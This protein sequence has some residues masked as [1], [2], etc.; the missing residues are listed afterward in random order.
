[1]LLNFYLY[2]RPSE[3]RGLRVRDVVK[4]VKKGP[5]LQVVELPVAPCRSGDTLEDR[6][7]GRVSDARPPLPAVFGAGALRKEK[8]PLEGQRRACVHSHAQRDQHLPGAELGSQ[9]PWPNRQASPLP[10][11]ARGRVPRGRQPPEKPERHSGSRPVANHQKREE[12][13][14]GQPGDSALRQP[15]PQRAKRVSRSGKAPQA[16]LP[17]PAL[18]PGR[19]LHCGFFLEIFSGSGRLGRTIQRMTGWMVLLWDITLGI[20]YDLTDYANQHKIYNWAK[21]DLIL[22][23]HVGTP[24]NSFSRARDQPGGPPPL[25]SDSHPLGLE[26]ADAAKVRIG[27]F[28][29]RFTVRFLFLCLSLGISATCENPAKSRLWICPPMFSFL[30][31]RQVQNVVT[32]FCAYGTAWRKST[33]IVGVHIDLS[34]IGAMR[35]VGSKRGL[36]LF[37]GCSHVPLTGQTSTGQWL[38]KL[39]EP[40][41][42]KLCRLLGQAFLN[43]E[44]QRIAR[45]FARQAGP[46]NA[47]KP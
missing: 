19:T 12:L 21:S 26:P 14:E 29:L 4:P 18:S 41:P 22:G 45:S 3:Y 9:G 39:A 42:W 23:G 6:P 28:L 47:A 31:R 38:T 32:E 37:T 43:Q 27:N 16:D 2:L 44:V 7:V 34:Y 20:E 36:C 8:T 40:Y 33:R 30:R 17:Q 25:R 24:C 35:C 1:M 5:G 15:G 46:P 13:R 11:P 10:A